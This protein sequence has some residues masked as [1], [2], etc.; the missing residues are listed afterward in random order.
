MSELSVNRYPHVFPPIE[1]FSLRGFIDFRGNR[2]GDFLEEFKAV[3]LEGR[4]YTG[5]L[6]DGSRT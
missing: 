3:S 4:G 6:V 5:P 2:V 1:H